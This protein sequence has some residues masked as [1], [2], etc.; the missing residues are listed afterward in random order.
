MNALLTEP[1]AGHYTYGDCYGPGVLYRGANFDIFCFAV[2][3]SDENVQSLL[4]PTFY[5]WSISTLWAISFHYG[6]RPFK[7]SIKKSVS[8]Y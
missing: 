7:I 2:S 8:I 3:L 4:V 1:F 5:F 6:Q